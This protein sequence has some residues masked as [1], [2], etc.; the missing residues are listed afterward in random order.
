[1]LLGSKH[2]KQRKR[3]MSEYGSAA[4]SV[5]LTAFGILSAAFGETRFLLHEDSM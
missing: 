5:F 1:M 3:G 4:F 2:G